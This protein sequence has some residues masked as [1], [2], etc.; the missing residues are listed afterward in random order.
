MRKHLLVLMSMLSLSTIVYAQQYGSFK[1][2]R[3]GRVYKTV[4]IGTQVW[5]AENLNTDRFRNGDLIPQ[6]KTNEEWMKAGQSKQAAFCYY[7][8]DQSLKVKYGNIYNAYATIDER[9]LCPNG[10]EMPQ[11][12]DYLTLLKYLGGDEVATYF[13]LK[14]KTG[15]TAFYN[16]TNSSGFNLIPSGWRYENGVFHGSEFVAPLMA[17]CDQNKDV[18]YFAVYD[19]MVSELDTGSVCETTPKE[20]GNFGSAIRCIKSSNNSNFKLEISIQQFTPVNYY[21]VWFEDCYW[22]IKQINLGS[23]LDTSTN[24]KHAA[25]YNCKSR[26]WVFF[27]GGQEYT[28]K[29]ISDQVSGQ[30]LR[31]FRSGDFTIH[32]KTSLIS[33]TGREAGLIYL[34]RGKKLLQSNE[35]VFE[36]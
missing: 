4:K 8:N 24:T 31:V 21:P 13:K 35:I 30:R 15:W 7:Q 34:Y 23:N 18:W 33:G 25:L 3:D 20:Y 11:K 36:L 14:S 9:G 6:A 1:D 17:F 22:G 12:K 28:S 26:A 16:G 19:R 27:I 2:A 32:T 5:M 10:Y 29:L